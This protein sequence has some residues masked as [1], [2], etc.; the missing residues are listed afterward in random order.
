M[1]LDNETNQLKENKFDL[2]DNFDTTSSFLQ[3]SFYYFVDPRYSSLG[4]RLILRNED[5]QKKSK[6]DQNKF[7]FF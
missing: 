2:S 5:P 6:G 1:S 7:N 4:Y 3:K